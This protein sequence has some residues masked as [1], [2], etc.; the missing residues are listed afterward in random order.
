MH[1]IL[2]TLLI[3]TSSIAYAGSGDTAPYNSLSTA[4]LEIQKRNYAGTEN[5]NTTQSAYKTD[6][7][8][9][10]LPVAVLR[11]QGVAPHLVFTSK[12]RLS[13]TTYERSQ[14]VNSLFEGVLAKHY[15]ETKHLN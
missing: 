4:V 11:K 7:N 13:A 6:N 3:M 5:T 14:T 8:L 9:N 1:K 2:T 10:S 12:S 15:F